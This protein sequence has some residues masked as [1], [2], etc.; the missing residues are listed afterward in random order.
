MK[1]EVVSFNSPF[2]GTQLTGKDILFLLT[3][4]TANAIAGVSGLSNKIA[5]IY[6]KRYSEKIS[7]PFNPETGYFGTKAI[8]GSFNNGANNL[9]NIIADFVELAFPN[10][11][12]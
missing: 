7:S 10:M 9:S 12:P 11:A 6:G 8:P 2:R 1:S 3:R 4:P 5:Q